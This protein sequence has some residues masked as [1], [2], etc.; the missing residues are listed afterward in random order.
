MKVE[1]II[2]VKYTN[3]VDYSGNVRLIVNGLRTKYYASGWGY[4]KEGD[5]FSQ[6]INDNFKNK[7]NKS[8]SSKGDAIRFINS[9]GGKFE[10]MY[11]DDD[12]DLYKIIVNSSKVIDYNYKITKNSKGESFVWANDR[13]LRVF[14]N[15]DF[16]LEYLEDLQKK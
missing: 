14:Y 2:R 12:I 1:F 15:E 7:E 4:D 9:I 3:S 11:Q 16:A 10:V 8:I 13:V 6:L 5:A